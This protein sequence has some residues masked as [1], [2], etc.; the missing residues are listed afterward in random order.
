MQLLFFVDPARNFRDMCNRKGSIFFCYWG[1]GEGLGMGTGFFLFTFMFFTHLVHLIVHRYW[2]SRYTMRI[3][4]LNF[5]AST[6]KK[7][8]SS[9][10]FMPTNAMSW[11][12]CWW[13][14]SIASSSRPS[15]NSK[16]SE[17]SKCF[18]SSISNFQNKKCI[19]ILFSHLFFTVWLFFGCF[20]FI[21]LWLSF[22]ENKLL[23]KL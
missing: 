22:L 14:R 17:Q 10:L 4:S 20:R 6:T 21:I 18:S 12:S 5:I 19:F 23:L 7:R 11:N 3:F 16:R 8:N 2:R 15:T 13:R 9:V 1:G